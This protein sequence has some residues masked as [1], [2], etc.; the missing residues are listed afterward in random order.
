VFG[1]RAS[2]I[3][4][5]LCLAIIGC[6]IAMAIPMV[7]VVAFAS[8]LGH[9]PTRAVELLSVL[10]GAGFLSRLA[11]GMLS[12]RIGGLPT[13]FF[14]SVV[15]A[16]GLSLFLV[17]DSLAGL[18][19]V[20][21]LFGIGFGAIL[22]CYAVIIREVFPVAEIGRRVGVVYFFGTLGMAMGGGLAG[23]LFDV[24][25]TYRV[26]FAVGIAFNLLNLALVALLRRRQRRLALGSAVR[27]SGVARPGG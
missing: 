7:H 19:V 24:T 15:Q 10:L 18:Y 11:W 5:T 16:G 22:P 26:A 17:V 2:T 4:G 9:P 25:G 6:C 3:Q 21:A 20:S 23:A 14:G 27:L 1:A 12:D 8:D 13:L